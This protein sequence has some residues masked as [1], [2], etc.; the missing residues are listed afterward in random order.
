VG[1][2][3]LTTRA[4]HL[5]AEEGINRVEVTPLPSDPA[6]GQDAVFPEGDF[7]DPDGGGMENGNDDLPPV[8]SNPIKQSSKVKGKAKPTGSQHLPRV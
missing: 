2:Q 8:D 5:I 7:R 4:T 3:P 1:I 6:M